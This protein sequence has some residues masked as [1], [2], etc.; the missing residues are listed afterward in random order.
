[1]LRNGQVFAGYTVERALGYGGMGSVY[2]ARHPR[3][4]RLIALKLLNQELFADTEIRAR[5]E[6][7]ADV[8]AQLDHANIVTVFDRGIE[9]GQLWISMQYV[10]GVDGE[11]MDVRGLDPLRAVRIIADTAN[12]LDFAHGR[13][14]L[15][16]DVKPANILVERAGDQ[17]A[18]RVFLTDFGIARVVNET[19]RL[20]RT[21]TFI[22]TLAYASPEQLSG[23]PLDHRSDQYSLACSL[24]RL[25]TGTV[26]FE[27]TNPVAVI[28]GHLQQP[29]PPVGSVRPGLP[30]ALDVAL[31]KA[32]A[33]RAEDRYGSCAE[34]AEAALCAFA[35]PAGA[36]PV[37]RPVP[38]SRLA[39]TQ[40]RATPP[41]GHPGPPPAGV[42]GPSLAGM[43]L[44]GLSSKP[45]AGHPI[46][47][48][49]ARPPV[50]TRSTVPTHL[51]RVSETGSWG[52]RRSVRAVCFDAAGSVLFSL[53]M[54]DKLRRWDLA[55]DR[56]TT[57][58]LDGPSNPIAAA[59]FLPGGRSVITGSD[60]GTVLLWDCATGRAMDIGFGRHGD[61][62]LAVAA[63]P[64]GARVATA[65][66]DGTVRSWDAATGAQLGAEVEALTTRAVDA[67]AFSPDGRLLAGGVT[68]NEVRLW[69]VDTGRGLWGSGAGTFDT[70]VESVAFAPGG[71]VLGA[72]SSDG[73]LRFWDLP[74]GRLIGFGVTENREPICVSAFSPDSRLFVTGAADS[75]VRF[76]DPATGAGLGRA[77]AV[78]SEV[79]AIA[80]GP[81]GDLLAVGT[82]KSVQV[83]K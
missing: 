56:T 24:F 12:A 27:A 60:N 33:K 43:S 11:S 45:P 57:T 35:G 77:L 17:G 36:A 55:T 76:W 14:V 44:A 22:A 10:D 37:T 66:A 75:A 53:D 79:G 23:V 16:R 25:L 59:A 54:A 6:R 18:G 8:V 7:E 26:P 3:L 65:S 39:P 70:A 5:F 72:G 82:H 52:F 4:P 20:T 28:Q 1:M 40:V 31:A 42:P 48:I 13:G 46:P 29:P 68:T 71:R 9:D 62:V 32:L 47:P 81:E 63:S 2:L 83:W 61:C 73:M 49:A 69:D 34:L 74:S 58:V 41:A 21:G 67:L 51:V 15:H 38:A 19:G 80:F 50:R 64:D 30:A 78:G